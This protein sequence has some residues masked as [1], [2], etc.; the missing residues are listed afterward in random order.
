[1]SQEKM[2]KSKA[3]T[4]VIAMVAR[5]NTPESISE[6]LPSGIQALGA[7]ADMEP[8]QANET[9]DSLLAEIVPAKAVLE[10]AIAI[11]TSMKV[12]IDDGN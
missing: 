9:I 7:L 1:M 4:V 3:L 5:L 12:G 11:I 8:E 6:A 10:E 2:S